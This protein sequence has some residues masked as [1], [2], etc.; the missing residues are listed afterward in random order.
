MEKKRITCPDSSL[1]KDE[2]IKY[3]FENI[4]E[5]IYSDC[6]RELISLYGGE[7]L[8]SSFGSD[9]GRDIADLQEFSAIW[10]FR[11]GTERWAVRDEKFALDNKVLIMEKA[12]GLGLTDI[13]EPSAEPDYIL[14]LGGARL[15]NYVR[16]KMAREVIDEYGYTGKTIAALSGTRPLNEIERPYTDDYA[17]YAETE[18]DA[19]CAGLE[20]AF[21]LSKFNEEKRMHDNINLNSAVRK[22]SGRY[23]DSEV[24]SLA[25]PSSDPEN[26][27]ANSYDTFKYLL[28][29]FD[30]Q[31][32]D[33]LLMVTSCIY[34]PFQTLKFMDLAIEGGFE[35]DCIGS[36]SV[37]TGNVSK[38]SNFLQEIKGTIDAIYTLSRQYD[39][40]LR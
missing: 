15:A 9:P 10:D 16:P 21:G 19:M 36:D 23:M 29:H 40:Y 34:V 6:L 22:Y 12:A 28:K 27:R 35:V 11:K 37:D 20:K 13:H 8:A 38:V 25:A 39:N 3:L 32:G 26:R 33:R 30:I 7:D 18:F 2:R 24:Y 31:A 17:P 14:P 1:P 4:S 5:W